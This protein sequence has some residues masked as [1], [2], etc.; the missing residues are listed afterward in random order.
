M[1]SFIDWFWILL[2]WFYSNDI[3]I[4]GNRISWVSLVFYSWLFLLWLLFFT[5]LWTYIPK[6]RIGKC[7]L[8]L[9][10]FILCCKLV[11]SLIQLIDVILYDYWSKVKFILKAFIV[12]TLFVAK[13]QNHP[14]FF[15]YTHHTI[16]SNVKSHLHVTKLN[17]DWSA[18]ID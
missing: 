5:Y 4:F 17:D 3:R 2:F 14:Q 12:T 6:I 18:S 10:L 7:R 15:L 1:S 13:P 9:L 16:Y 8:F 11:F